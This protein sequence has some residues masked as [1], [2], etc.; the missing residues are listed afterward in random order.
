MEIIDEIEKSEIKINLDSLY[1]SRKNDDLFKRDDLLDFNDKDNTFLYKMMI[2]ISLLKDENQDKEDEIK[3]LEDYNEELSNYVDELE[4]EIKEKDMK[5]EK[6]KQNEEEYK[7]EMY[8]LIYCSNMWRQLSEILL[9][10]NII[11]IS[12]LIFFKY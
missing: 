3:R 8:S 1:E 9:F 7:R 5:E 6:Y 4:K 10:V 11:F 12:S 2:Y